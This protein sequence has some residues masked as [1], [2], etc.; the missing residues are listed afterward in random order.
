M[1]W[2]EVLILGEIKGLNSGAGMIAFGA[3]IIIVILYFISLF[4][5]EKTV[6]W[7]TIIFSTI[8]LLAGLYYYQNIQDIIEKV[9][10]LS[11]ITMFGISVGDM[12]GDINFNW[13]TGFSLTL[14][15]G[16]VSLFVSF[17]LL[18]IAD[19]KPQNL[20]KNISN[21]PKNSDYPKLIQQ[22]NI[23]TVSNFNNEPYI[24][25]LKE[26]YELNQNGVISSDIYEEEKSKILG[27]QKE[28]KTKFDELE[29]EELLQQKSTV[30]LS[31]QNINRPS[32]I[33]KPIPQKN[34]TDPNIV[35]VI[36]ACLLL[37]GFAVYSFASNK[38]SGKNNISETKTDKIDSLKSQSKIFTKKE[39]KKEFSDINSASFNVQIIDEN[40]SIQKEYY[41]CGRY[42]S[43]NKSDYDN[44]KYLVLG[45]Y[46]AENHQDFI[47]IQ[48]DG[49][50]EKLFFEN[51]YEKVYNYENDSFSCQ[52]LY[53][54]EDFDGNEV[55]KITG[56]IFI[57]N[58]ITGK[59]YTSNIYGIA[60]C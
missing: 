51:H 19:E 12:Y 34:N 9:T 3:F 26:L 10:S 43:K 39:R 2:V 41:G 57:R 23:S 60:G 32:Y 22:S 17:V 25:K 36:V 29:K 50:D 54:N 45:S 48:I 31:P 58:K 27:L 4:S 30:K 47:D 6:L 16:G 20:K 5:E 53:I 15:S 38:N 44:N 28:N 21:N 59:K 49:I 56:K 1:V 42:L 11:K 35:F 52:I 8:P 13:K 14:L 46:T 24:Q 7:V 40:S 55:T 33:S 37:I 18:M